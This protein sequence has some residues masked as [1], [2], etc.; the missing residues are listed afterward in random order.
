M[1][2]N[3][4]DVNL[5]LKFIHKKPLMIGLISCLGIVAYS[6]SFLCSFHLDDTASIVK[7]IF[8][9]NTQDL[10]SIWNF[11]P[12]R[13]VTYLSFA[14]NYRSSGLNVLS[15]HL[16]NV[17]VH[18]VSAILVWWLTLLTFS[19]P[20]MK[21]NK[22]VRYGG[23]IAL[24]AGLIFVGH[25][26]Q[27]E[28]V[29][30]IVQRASSMAALFYLASLCF[31]IKARLIREERPGESAWSPNYILSMAMAIL[32]MFTKET[33]I[34]LPLMMALYEFSFF[35]A[36]N[37]LNWKFL[38]PFLVTLLIIPLTMFLTKSVNFQE[39]HRISEPSSSLSP[40]QYLS[41]QLRVMITYVRLAFFPFNQNI[42][43]DYPIFKNILG[44][45]VLGSLIIL[46]AVFVCAKHLFLKY[47]LVSFSIFW[48]FL[49][50]S[51][52]SSLL[53]IRDVIF[54]HRLYLSMAGYSI[55]LASSAYYLFGKKTEEKA[56]MAVLMV[57][58]CYSIL[59]YQRNEV[60]RNNIT[61]WGDSAAK[62]FHKVRPHNNLGL[63]YFNQGNPGQAILEYNNAIKAGPGVADPY[64]NRG[65]AYA[66][67][68]NLK[69]AMEDFNKAIEISPSNEL[70]YYNK[71][72]AE[73]QKRETQ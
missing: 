46:T 19:T 23:S 7:N 31:Y 22:I 13:F 47:R 21:E 54:E 34:T 45:P 40:L 33:S 60:W 25:P 27:T 1:R 35:R 41:T 17:T 43:Y 36:N 9:R 69:Q 66:K 24:L 2:G 11:W 44:A 30:Y 70:A 57:I 68:G 73:E 42:D 51:P 61:L 48:F 63:A 56:L 26:I 53:P 65:I 50:L 71:A 58:I 38:A 10:Q 52:E 37:G 72:R 67:L 59:T 29:T 20:V 62:S 6:N 16:F 8:I 15:Y 49:A 12:C 32:A 18:I 5:D 55:F 14:L 4:D 28:A 3:F 39:M 64:I